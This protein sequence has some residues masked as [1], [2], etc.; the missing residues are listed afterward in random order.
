MNCADM[1][2]WLDGYMDGKLSA[3]ER[4]ALES[5]AATCAA[6]A[7]KLEATRALMDMMEELSPEMDVP[8]EAQAAWR[9]AVKRSSKAGRGRIVRWAGGIAAALIVAVGAVSLLRGAPDLAARHVE[10]AEVAGE[11]VMPEAT[12]I[13]DAEVAYEEA[14]VPEVAAIEADGVAA[15]VKAAGS[16]EEMAEAAAPMLEYQLTVKDLDEA[17][18]RIEDLSAEYEGE[19]S[20]QS[21]VANG[22]ECANAYVELPAANAAEFMSALEPF[23]L[24]GSLPEPSFDQND[25]AISLMLMLRAE[26]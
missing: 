18:R 24:D 13:E 23:N 2:R 20:L 5:H 6:C 21:F 4:S 10:R 15:S 11:A 7:K 22:V 16:V 14:L 3:D 26:S 19:V 12:A 25:G 17:C 1:D 9:S 8:L